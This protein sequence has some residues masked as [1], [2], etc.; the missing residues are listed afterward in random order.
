MPSKKNK[1]TTGFKD[2]LVLGSDVMRVRVEVFKRRKPFQFK[3]ESRVYNYHKGVV[4]AKITYED[5]KQ[6]KR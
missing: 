1:S 5:C 6:E 4:D 3:D 2:V